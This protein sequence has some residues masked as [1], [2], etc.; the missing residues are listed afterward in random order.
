MVCVWFEMVVR[1]EVRVLWFY[2][3]E[4]ACV[5]PPLISAYWQ[6]SRV[7]SSSQAFTH[8]AAYAS[9]WHASST[10]AQHLGLIAVTLCRIGLTGCKPLSDQQWGELW[11]VLVCVLP[12]RGGCACGL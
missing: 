10:A 9:D 4:C 12:L 2:W 7:S 1:V 5:A 3:V 6:L 8:L 11:G